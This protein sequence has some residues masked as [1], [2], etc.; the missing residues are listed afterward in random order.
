MKKYINKLLILALTIFM[1]SCDDLPDVNIDPNNSTTARPQE[2]LTS[3]LFYTAFIMDAQ[4]NEEAYLWAQYWTWGTGVSL[5]DNARYIQE[6][7]D[8]N[9]AWTRSYRDVLA[10]LNFLKKSENPAFRGIA[11]TL[12]VFVY[13]YLVDHFGDVPYSQAVKGA[14]EDGSILAP[15]YDDDAA[16]YPQLVTSLDEAISELVAAQNDPTA[17][18][19]VHGEDLIYSGDLHYWQK[20]ANSLKLRVLLRMSSVNDVSSDVVATVAAREFIESNLENCAVP[21]SGTSGNENPM[22]AWE[23]SGIGNFYK[24]ATT[25][26]DVCDQLSDPRKFAF[27]DAAVN[28]PG[29]IRAGDQN[30]IALDFGAV[31]E[32]WSDPAAITYAADESTYFMTAWETWFLR[33]EAA[34]RYGTVDDE[35]EAFRNGIRASFEYFGVAD[36]EDY[37]ANLGYNS[38]A[39]LDERIEMIAV[40]KWLSMCGKQEAEGWIEARRFD[41]P[42]NPIFTDGIYQTPLSSSLPDGVFPTRWLYPENE[43]NLNANFPGQVTITDKV[44]WDE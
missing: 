26:T 43:Q 42:S 1:V 29:E 44:F 36:V 24:A 10:D 31:S 25:V 3:A 41:T 20:F 11:R 23:E 9:Q 18:A 35:V 6:P 8:N 14:I 22:F 4:Y 40:Q 13:Q 32:D 39:S 5:G 27:Y 28:F 16:I 15:A 2:V 37:I 34:A 7:R 12:E 38:G 21:F 19:S 33:A 17:S 30:E